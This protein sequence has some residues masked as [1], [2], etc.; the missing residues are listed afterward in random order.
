MTCVFEAPRVKVD[1]LEFKAAT[2]RALNMSM[3]V[4]AN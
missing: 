1:A 3:I 2:T 4:G